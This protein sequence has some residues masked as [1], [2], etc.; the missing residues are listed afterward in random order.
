MFEYP[1]DLDI[2]EA[3]RGEL[4]QRSLD[5]QGNPDDSESWEDVKKS[6]QSE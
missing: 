3:Q 2:T 4:E 5:L 6:L 1:E